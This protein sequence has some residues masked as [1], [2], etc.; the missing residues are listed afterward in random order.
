MTSSTTDPP[1]LRPEADSA[2][3][4]PPEELAPQAADANFRML[5]DGID[6]Y[7]IFM[8]DPNGHVVTWK[9]RGSEDQGLCR[10]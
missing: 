9:Y 10:A 4:R 6:N 3:V 7:A 5:V 8:L 2:G 1:R